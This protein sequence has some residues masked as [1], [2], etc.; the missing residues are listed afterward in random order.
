MATDDDVAI[1]RGYT[2]LRDEA[3]NLR[4]RAP[5]KKRVEIC[6]FEYFEDRACACFG[7]DPKRTQD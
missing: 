1:P 7:C 2:L 3:W 6:G 5:E 4:N